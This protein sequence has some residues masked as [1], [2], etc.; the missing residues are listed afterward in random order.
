MMLVIVGVTTLVFMALAVLIAYLI[1]CGM[2]VAQEGLNISAFEAFAV[3]METEEVSQA[4]TLDMIL[5][6]VF[7]VVGMVIEIVVLAKSI[8]RN[9]GIN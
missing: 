8:K 9:K 5:A 6:M 7:A 2:A 4:F 1:I 3:L